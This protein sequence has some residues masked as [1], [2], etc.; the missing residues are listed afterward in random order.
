MPESS[1]KI[2]SQRQWM[3]D[4]RLRK[5]ERIIIDM[6]E[7]IVEIKGRKTAL[8]QIVAYF[9]IYQRLTQNQIHTLTGLSK[10]TISPILQFLLNIDFLHKEKIPGTHTNQYIMLSNTVQYVTETLTQLK[11]YFSQSAIFFNDIHRRIDPSQL[12]SSKKILL[13]RVASMVRYLSEF[14]TMMSIM[15]NRTLMENRT[16][17]RPIN[18]KNKANLT[19]FSDIGEIEHEIVDFFIKSPLFYFQK[20]SL[21]KLFGLLFINESLSQKQLKQLSGF[22]SGAI[23][24]DL[25]VLEAFGFVIREP[26]SHS[27]SSKYAYK[28]VPVS[29]TLLKLVITLAETRMRWKPVLEGMKRELEDKF[30]ELS[31]LNGY[32]AIYTIISVL[33]R[34]MPIYEELVKQAKIKLGSST[35]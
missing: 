7:E 26:T 34:Y 22:S 4:S 29:T 10:G 30:V 25:K 2:S 33:I 9:F 12:P 11:A 32:N 8:G 16:E 21:S 17:H 1:P 24:Q 3:I 15:E 19:Q 6:F 28:M 23:S 13:D 27:R 5:Y 35:V 31:V 14:M 18:Q 20:S